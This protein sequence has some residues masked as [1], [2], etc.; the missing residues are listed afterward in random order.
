AVALQEEGAAGEVVRL[1]ASVAGAPA[2]VLWETRED[3]FVP[4]A[5][6]GVD[7]TGE[8]GAARELA[9]RAL[10]DGG[11]VTAHAAGL[12]RDCPAS[13]AL[14]LGRPLLGV[15]QLFH[16]AGEEPETEQLTRLAT[17]G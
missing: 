5:S 17:F 11:P 7:A 1:A 4:V 3:G 14:P 13:T 16:P 8:L 6:W 2:A 9:E 15:L 12:P 10:G